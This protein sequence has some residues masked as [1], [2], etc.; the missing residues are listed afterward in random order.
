MYREVQTMS[1]KSRKADVHRTVSVKPV[2]LLTG[3]ELL[4]DMD[5]YRKNVTNT[6]GAARD[7]LVRLGVMTKDGKTKNLIRG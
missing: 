3:K 7:F 2:R 5:V 1:A 6:P 4:D